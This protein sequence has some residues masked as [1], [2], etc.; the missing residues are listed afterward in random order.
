MLELTLHKV[1]PAWRSGLFFQYFVSGLQSRLFHIVS[2][3][4]PPVSVEVFMLMAV[5]VVL[6]NTS[7][8]GHHDDV[9]Q[10]IGI[11]GCTVWISIH[12][13]FF[14]GKEAVARLRQ[15]NQRTCY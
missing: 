14:Q 15:S 13:G 12:Q 11:A 8:G 6:I 3:S 5:L 4:L 7:Q 1:F 10:N 9:E 2:F